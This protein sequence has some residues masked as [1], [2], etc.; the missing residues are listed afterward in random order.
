[1]SAD[2]SSRFTPKSG[3]EHSARRNR[4]LSPERRAEIARTAAAARWRKAKGDDWTPPAE[5]ISLTPFYEMVDEQW[6]G[7]AP[8]ART[9]QA[10][11]LRTE[12][13]RGAR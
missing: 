13:R 1:M 4:V 3:A 7:L 8:T 6:P 10:E 11:R 9:A 2:K 12:Y 5:D